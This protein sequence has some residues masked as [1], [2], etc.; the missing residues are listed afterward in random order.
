MIEFTTVVGV[1]DRYIKELAVVWPNWRRYRPEIM[2]NPLLFICDGDVGNK[3][4]WEESLR[5]IV[6]D[7]GFSVETWSQKG[8]SQREKMLNALSIVPSYAVDTDW[9]LKIDCDSFAVDSGKWIDESWF[10][11]NPAFVASPWGYTKPPK[12]LADCERWS[13]SVPVLR[14]LPPVVTNIDESERRVRHRRIISYVYFGNTV[15]HRWAVGW[16]SISGQ[17]TLPCP[18]QDTFFS[19]L[20]A[21]TASPYRRVRMKSF[22]WRHSHKGLRQINEDGTVREST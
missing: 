3:Q 5:K 22:G 16:L 9:F 8:V 7:V 14:D 20:A 10:D 11:A 19:W 6:G 12:M 18:S 4:G 17:M 21:K 13:E 2:S 1:D 15:W